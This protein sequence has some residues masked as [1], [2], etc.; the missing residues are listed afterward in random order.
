MGTRDRSDPIR[1]MT[2]NLRFDTV[3]DGPAG[4]RWG[5]RVESVVETIRRERPD[6]IGFQEA[7]ESQLSDMTAALPDHRGVG[8]PRDVGDTAEY[9]PLFFHVHRFELEE[10]GDFWL[11]PTPDVEGSRGWDTDA[12]RH[13]TWARLR[14]RGSDVGFAAFNTHLDVK[15]SLARLEASKLIVT[16]VAVAPGVPAVVM[17][18]FNTPEGSEPL[19]TFFAA[20]FRDTFR[21]VHPDAVDVQTVHHYRDLSGPRKIDFILCGK[22][23]E[24]LGSEIVREPAA[25]R[26]PSDHFPIWADLM[27]SPTPEEES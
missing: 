2:F 17:G 24:I 25:G 4:N 5:D 9:V 22:Q 11:S 8:K 1:F 13:C 20:G 19:E 14:E 7:L 15:G 27:A 23:W 18:D 26:L 10:Q 3:R 6:V 12:P 21:A 16:K